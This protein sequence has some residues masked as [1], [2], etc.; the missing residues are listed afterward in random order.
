MLSYLFLFILSH[1]QP[2][3][4]VNGAPQM[5]Q[6]PNMGVVPGPMPVPGPGPGPGPGQGPV[7]P[8]GNHQTACILASP[9]E[10]V[11]SASPLCSKY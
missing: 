8:P 3:M 11:V 5:M 2:G 4:H 10:P 1:D 9:T 6:P 7:G